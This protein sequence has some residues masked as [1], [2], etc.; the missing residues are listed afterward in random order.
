MKLMPPLT[1]AEPQVYWCDL[2]L[3]NRTL[4]RSFNFYHKEFCTAML[5]TEMSAHGDV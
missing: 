5:H 1:D 4:M 2:V 3:G